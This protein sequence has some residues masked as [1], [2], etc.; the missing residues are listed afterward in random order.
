M[1]RAAWV[2]PMTL[3]QK[4][5]ANEAV[6]ATSCFKILCESYTD[7]S[8]MV[9]NAN[10]NDYPKWETP[11]SHGGWVGFGHNK[12]HD[13]GDTILEYGENYVNFIS[14]IGGN[15]GHV[16]SWIDVNDNKVVDA[17]DRVYWYTDQKWAL[18]YYKWNHWGTIA[19]VD[20]SHPNHS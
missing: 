3:V 5:E 1:V 12:C 13:Y 6:A 4:F 19:S 20:P 11:Q 2:K 8:N 14:E 10:P 15:N 7:Y 16:D 17:G 9:D 18:Q